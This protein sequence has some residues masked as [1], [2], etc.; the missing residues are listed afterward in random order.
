MGKANQTTTSF[1]SVVIIKCTKD[2][3]ECS[4]ILHPPKFEKL[5]HEF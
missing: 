1:V 2:Y 5:L 4:K 3:V